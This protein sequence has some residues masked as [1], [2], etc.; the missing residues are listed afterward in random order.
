MELN[1]GGIQY[2]YKSG[3]KIEDP[4]RQISLDGTIISQACALSDL[5]VIALVKR[6]IGALTENINTANILI[7]FR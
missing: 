7:F 1:L 2:L 6:N 3:A 4:D 5:S